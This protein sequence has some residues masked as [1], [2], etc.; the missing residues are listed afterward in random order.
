MVVAN[1]HE[2]ITLRDEMYVNGKR[3]YEVYVNG[4]KVYPEGGGDTLFIVDH[5]GSMNGWS[6]AYG[7]KRSDA[8]IEE[9]KNHNF[10]KSYTLCGLTNDNEMRVVVNWTTSFEEILDV[11]SNGDFSSHS[12]GDP[13]VAILATYEEY[14]PNSIVV[15]SDDALRIG[16]SERAALDE[17][18]GMSNLYLINVTNPPDSEQEE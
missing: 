9:M 8:A 1:G 7:M 10:G 2:F 6:P 14:Q 12:F 13:S 11:N 16:E 3:V 5:S 15:I 17:L 18:M 4:V